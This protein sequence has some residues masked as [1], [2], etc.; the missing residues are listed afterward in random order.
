MHRLVYIRRVSG[1]NQPEHEQHNPA[2]EDLCDVVGEDLLHD[3]SFA[4]IGFAAVIQKPAAF[5][6]M[7]AADIS[8]VDRQRLVFDA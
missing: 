5:F 3:S 6:T 7:P 1:Q 8:S 2:G 4:N